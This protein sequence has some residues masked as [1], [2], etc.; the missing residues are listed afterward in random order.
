[1]GRARR[2][3]PPRPTSHAL[4][5]THMQ[6][7][8]THTHRHTHR[9]HTHEH[10]LRHAQKRPYTQAHTHHT[11]THIHRVIPTAQAPTM[12]TY[13]HGHI[14]V[15]SCTHTHRHTHIH[16]THLHTHTPCSKPISFTMGLLCGFLPQKPPQSH[17][18]LPSVN[19]LLKPRGSGFS[20]HQIAQACPIETPSLP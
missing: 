2:K 9:I 18:L 16:P 13:T 5:H 4:D 10:S 14:H 7:T 12:H 11:C 17:L 3:S 8:E 15:H 6:Y 19:Q 20:F 1:M